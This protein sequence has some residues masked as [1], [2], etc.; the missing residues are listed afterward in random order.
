M[1]Y[2]NEHAARLTDPGKYKR[3]AR[4][5]D[6]FGVGI[7]AIFGIL[8]DGKT[9]LQAIRFSKK[10]FTIEQV[11]SW[12]SEHKH[13]AI[14]VEK[15]SGNEDGTIHAARFDRGTVGE[16]TRRDD[17]SILADAVVTRSG[18][19]S[20]HNADGTV[21]RELRHPDNIFRLDSLET[22]KL[23]PVTNGH[24]TRLVTP[25]TVQ[26]LKVGHTG[27]NVRPDGRNIRATLVIDAAEG[28]KAVDKGRRELSLGYEVD[29][30]AQDG[31]YDGERYD[32]VQT[33]IRYNHLALV[34]SARAGREARLNIDGHGDGESLVHFDG[35][36]AIEFDEST[37]PNPTN[38]TRKGR[39]MPTLVLDGISYE[40]SQEVINAHAREKARAD[41]AEADLKTSN[42]SLSTVTAERDDV[43]DKLEKAEKVDHNEE[44]NKRVD[45]RVRLLGIANK[46]LDE[47]TRKKLD[48]MDDKTIKTE[49][50]VSR[51]ANADECRK[52]L[53]GKDEAYLDARFDAAIENLDE[54]KGDGDDVANQRRAST[55]RR[56]GKGGDDDPVSKARNDMIDR[57]RNAYKDDEGKKTDK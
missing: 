52:V 24:P 12:L 29:L 16:V 15:A 11:R 18:V 42:E 22:M 19:F 23:I 14:K 21:R 39:S 41:K 30:V 48:E 31:V 35:A 55:P 34:D 25:E 57:Q 10:K 33:N 20:Y 6:K 51:S 53:D 4:Q 32:F 9:E 56:D 2:P 54:D 38:P 26:A 49:I 45:A 37:N 43:K 40:A 17:G 7:D 3:F 8:P 44:I 1:P 47:E 50:I 46:V 5:N 27:E 28:I 13:S 36:D